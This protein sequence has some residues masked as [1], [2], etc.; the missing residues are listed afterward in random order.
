M[1][2]LS[3]TIIDLIRHGETTSGNCYLGS[4]DSLL[5]EN[6]WQQMRAA[7]SGLTPWDIIISSPLKRCKIYAEEISNLNNI[8]LTIERAFQEINFG[9]FDGKTSKQLMQSNPE[10]LKRFWADPVKNTPPNG[11]QFLIFKDRI[12]KAWQSLLITVI[13]KQACVVTHA[14]VIRTIIQNI[15]DMPDDKLFRL[16]ITHGGITRI[17]LDGNVSEAIPRLVFINNNLCSHHFD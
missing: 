10:A 15:L 5:S 3:H 14:G 6:G 16:D 17:E 8:P 12:L 2:G 4:T 1:S 9:D 7:T 11:E 13:N